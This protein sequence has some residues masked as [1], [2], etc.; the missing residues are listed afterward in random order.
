[1]EHQA[2]SD[3]VERVREICLERALAV[4]AENVTQIV[5][6]LQPLMSPS[7]RLET[8]NGILAQFTGLGVLDELLLI[9]GVT[10]ILVNSHSE[11]WI[12]KGQG[13]QRVATTFQDEK[14]LR[15][16]AVR[17]A[18]MANRRLD[19]AS[20][21]V[22]ARMPNG[23]RLHAV[24][25]PLSV[26]GTTISLRI[27]AQADFTLR[28][29][30]EA[31][32][33]SVTGAI[34]LEKVISANLSMIICGGTGS[35]KTTVLNSLLAL[36]SPKKRIVVVEDSQELYVSHPHVVALQARNCNVEGLGAVTM[37]TL[38]R[39]ALRMRPDRIV[40][41][42]VRGEEIVDL[43]SALNTG[44]EGGATT[45]H[46]N[47]A[48]SVPARVESLGLMS[49]L[50]LLAIRKQLIC[51]VQVVVDLTRDSFGQ[52]MLSGLHVLEEG[53]TGEV[54]VLKAIDLNTDERFEP[55]YKKLSDL[56]KSRGH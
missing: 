46:A 20:P 23:V 54:T 5:R 45:I 41:G 42:E 13:T 43:L 56:F 10:D 3:L 55:G 24:I 27:P 26:S 14:E 51:G 50:P 38:V 34:L 15:N 31:G 39:Q 36:V 52:R 49:G 1:M 9:Q 29:L 44:H 17:L 40:V 8:V 12:D 53:A 47:S 25:P 35:G 33:V 37:R 22:D 21:W 18:S 28:D 11:I 4:S 6:E 48:S 19:E 2:M 7:Q 32:S 30:V 16:F